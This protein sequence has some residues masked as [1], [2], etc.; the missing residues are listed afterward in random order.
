M[1]VTES[2][3]GTIFSLSDILCTSDPYGGSGTNNN[4]ISIANRNVAI[5]LEEGDIVTCTFVNLVV[6]PTASPI[7]ISGRVATAAGRPLIRA[8]VSVLNETTGETRYT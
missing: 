3:T 4:T 2:F 7:W 1:I 8:M 6:G 5:T